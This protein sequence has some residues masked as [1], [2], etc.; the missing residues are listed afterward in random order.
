[1][2]SLQSKLICVLIH[3]SML[4]LA[5]LYS[6]GA[7][8]FLETGTRG[9]YL[10]ILNASQRAKH[11]EGNMFVYEQSP[12]RGS[13]L[14]CWKDTGNVHTKTYTHTHTHISTQYTAHLRSK[15]AHVTKKQY[16]NYP[17]R[18]SGVC[19]EY[20]NSS[21]N[22]RLVCARECVQYLVLLTQWGRHVPSSTLKKISHWIY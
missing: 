3:L 1:M 20:L 10:L 16:T 9:N 6:R 13:R 5:P 7:G 21:E 18:A 15:P 17:S 12:S 22:Y 2:C 4:A 11:A 14:I 19:V 8:S